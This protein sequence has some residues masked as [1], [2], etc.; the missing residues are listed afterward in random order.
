MVECVA[1]SI[2][3]KA[4]IDNFGSYMMINA[5]NNKQTVSVNVETDINSEISNRV[6][7][8][9]NECIKCAS[10]EFLRNISVELS[11]TVK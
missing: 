11:V 8:A 5:K 3:A 4:P 9:I 1:G 2:S 6:E 7:T 10:K